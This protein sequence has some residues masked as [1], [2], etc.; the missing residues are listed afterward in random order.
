M[1]ISELLIPFVVLVL[2]AALAWIFALS[3]HVKRR[4]IRIPVR[5]TASLGMLLSFLFLVLFTVGTYACE[6]R[7]PSTYSP[8]GKHVAVLTWGLQGALGLDLADVTVRHRW[9]P[10]AKRAYFG[11]GDSRNGG[12]PHVRWIDNKHLLIR[13]HDYGYAPGTGYEQS[14]VSHVLDIDVKCEKEPN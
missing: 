3:P 6:A 1:D 4:L 7:A 2:G 5:I 11:P 14:C 13:Y 12:D 9:S 8:D 10:L